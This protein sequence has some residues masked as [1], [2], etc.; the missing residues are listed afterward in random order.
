M[1][2]SFLAVCGYDWD[3]FAEHPLMTE[4]DEVISVETLIIFHIYGSKK[5]EIIAKSLDDFYI[6]KVITQIAF[7]IEGL[8]SH[9]NLWMIQIEVLINDYD[10][11]YKIIEVSWNALNSYTDK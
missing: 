3:V 11:F 6:F 7:I 10:L 8:Y 5:R 9:N 2:C 1:H 4:I